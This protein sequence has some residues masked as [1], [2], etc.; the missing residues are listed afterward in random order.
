MGLVNMLAT[1]YRILARSM[2]QDPETVCRR[3][4]DKVNETMQP[5][6]IEMR[7]TPEMLKFIR[8]KKFITLEEVV[9][10]VAS[11]DQDVMAEII[12]DE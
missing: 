1:Q 11:P 2:V 5:A 7:F 9:D 12:A 3:I 10:T 6:G 4:R 8:N